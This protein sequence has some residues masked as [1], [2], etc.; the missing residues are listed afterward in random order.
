MPGRRSR[1]GGH[2][3][4][5]GRYRRS[6]RELALGRTLEG[7][8]DERRAGRLAEGSRHPA[9][10]RRDRQ[11]RFSQLLAPEKLPRVVLEV[12]RELLDVVVE[13]LVHHERAD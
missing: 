1:R 2:P 4:S 3:D 13:L 8:E 5:A 7:G 11:R 9:R 12:P 6:G 10:C